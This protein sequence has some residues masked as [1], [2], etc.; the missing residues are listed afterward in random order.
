MTMR[1]GLSEICRMAARTSARARPGP[2]SITSTPSSPACT[3]MFRAGADEHVH[4][5]LDVDESGSR[6]AES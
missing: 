5:S 1:I 6:Q 3:M 4:V 2:V